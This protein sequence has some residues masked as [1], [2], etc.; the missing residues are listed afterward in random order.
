MLAPILRPAVPSLGDAAAVSQPALSVVIATYNRPE[1]VARLLTL[2]ANQ[3]LDRAR[4]EVIVVDDGSDEHNVLKLNEITAPYRLQIVKQQNAGPAAARHRAILQ[5][6]GEVI[7]ILDDD[8]SVDPDFLAEHLSAHPA[9]SRVALLGRLRIRDPDSFPVYQRLHIHLNS[10][11]AEEAKTGTPLSGASVYTGN[12]SFLRSDY[13]AVGGFDQNLRLSED[14]E[15]GMRFDA[16]G[17]RIAFS[18]RAYSWHESPPATLRAWRNGARVYGRADSVISRKHPDIQTANPWRFLF[19]VNPI[20]RPFLLLATAFPRIATAMGTLVATVSIWFDRL[21][22]ESMALAGSTL[23]YGLDYYTGVRSESAA[24]GRGRDGL[25]TYLNG[26]EGRDLRPLA[27]VAKFYA[28]V[29]ADHAVLTSTNAKYGSAAEGS[30]M[31]RDLI[32]KVGFQIMAV[33]RLMRLLRD[34]GDKLAARILSR[35]IRHLYGAEIHWDTNLAPGVIIVHGTG[36]VISRSARV[37]RGCILFQHVTLGS[38]IDP[39]TRVVGA[40]TLEPD[41]HVGPGATILGPV[42]VGRSSKIAAGSVVSS[43]IPANSLVEP[44]PSVVR[45]R[46]AKAPPG[47]TT[48]Q[49]EPRLPQER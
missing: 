3:T 49:V 32:E 39:E 4:Y 13:F 2:L 45:P 24:T 9:G 21:G 8:M 6:R 22:F 43:S 28:D 42:T 34:L 29:K 15:L 30:G 31:F 35:M 23:V 7:V 16:H 46:T 38:N 1:S 40:P 19:M 27:R 37:A 14:S 48:N 36:L 33:Y 20:S 12:L 11:L 26:C 44:P 17:V 47:D 25:W 41:V 10:K 18:D 5:A